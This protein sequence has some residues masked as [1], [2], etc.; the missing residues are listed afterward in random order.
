MVIVKSAFTPVSARA[1][2]QVF[3][4]LKAETRSR[5]GFQS[6]IGNLQSSIFHGLAKVAAAMI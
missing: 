4:F 3:V 2:R 1:S 5:F 6:S